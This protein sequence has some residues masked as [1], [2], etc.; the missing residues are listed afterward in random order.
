MQLDI[1]K[2]ETFRQIYC[3]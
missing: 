3:S 1:G 2:L